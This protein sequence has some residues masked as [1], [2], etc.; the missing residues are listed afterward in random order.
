MEAQERGGFQNDGGP[1]QPARAHQQ[2]AYAGDHAITEAEVGGTSP[3]AIENQQLLLDE[4]GL[5]HHGTR[6]PGTGEPDDSRQQMEK[7][8]GEIAHGPIV[9]SWP[10]PGNA[11]EI[12]IRHAHVPIAR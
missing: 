2:R 4:D 5:G 9:T 6:T 7:Q 10:N 3:G 8:D 1:D 11:K 12:G